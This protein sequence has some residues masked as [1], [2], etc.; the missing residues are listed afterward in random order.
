MRYYSVV[1][2]RHDCDFAAREKIAIYMH[3]WIARELC[4][5]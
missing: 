1:A 4:W 3:V 5:I 2:E